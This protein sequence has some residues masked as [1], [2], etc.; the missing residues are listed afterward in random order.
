VRPQR[1]APLLCLAPAGEWLCL[2]NLHLAVSWLPALEKEL[3]ALG[4]ARAQG[5]RLLLTAEPHT[6]FPPTLLAACTKVRA[7]LGTLQ[8]AG[9]LLRAPA[10][11]PGHETRSSSN[12]RLAQVAFEAPPGVKK[13]LQRTYEGWSEGHLAAG[14]P[15]RAQLLFVLAW[16]HAIV[17]VR[18][19]WWR[20]TKSAAVISCDQQQPLCCGAFCW[21]SGLD[22]S[23]SMTAYLAPPPPLLVQERRAHV[24]AGWSKPYEFSLADLRS[25]ADIIELACGEG[26]QAGQAGRTAAVPWQYLHG[27]LESAIYGGRVDNAWDMRVRWAAGQRRAGGTWRRLLL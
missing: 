22:P 25:G 3:H 24:P 20:Q 10:R 21:C 16:F 17:Q 13:N 27:L 7:W 23:T 19:T 4:A 18:T 14:G 9:A 8:R 6:R 15:V 26:R 1:L 11:E 12:H 5:F 2:K